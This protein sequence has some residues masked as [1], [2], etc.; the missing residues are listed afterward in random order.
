MIR[1]VSTWTL[2]GHSHVLS[3]ERRTYERRVCCIIEA[4]ARP[5]ND[6]TISARFA[7][8]E[9]RKHAQR[10][11]V[12]KSLN[13]PNRFSARTDATRH[14]RTPDDR[15]LARQ[16]E[17]DGTG[18]DGPLTTCG[19]RWPT[20][21]VRRTTTTKNGEH[22]VE[23]MNN[24]CPQFQTLRHIVCLTSDRLILLSKVTHVSRSCRCTRSDETLADIGLGKALTAAETVRWCVINCPGYWNVYTVLSNAQLNARVTACTSNL[25]L[26]LYTRE[27]KNKDNF[28][29]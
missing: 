9:D 11:V 3:A 27:P 12:V 7:A 19:H 16:T 10:A 25:I 21:C 2:Y 4:G 22:A 1:E 17:R 26:Y 14:A 5:G 28:C 15:Q 13:C 23:W 20:Y 8:F 18:R 6:A 24:E 29:P